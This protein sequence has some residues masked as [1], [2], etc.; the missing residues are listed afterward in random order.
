MN[1]FWGKIRLEQIVILAEFLFIYLLCDT[2]STIKNPADWIA[3]AVCIVA[4]IFFAYQIPKLAFE[5]GMDER[6]EFY[7]GLLR[8]QRLTHQQE[9]DRNRAEYNARTQVLLAEALARASLQEVQ[10]N[11]DWDVVDPETGTEISKPKPKRKRK[12]K[13]KP[14]EI[15]VEEITSAHP[16]KPRDG[17]L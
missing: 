13:A 3:V 4:I 10:V 5:E 17:I 8:S 16:P 2:V 6:K 11:S 9:I 7:G 1:K 15:N 12:A 14:K